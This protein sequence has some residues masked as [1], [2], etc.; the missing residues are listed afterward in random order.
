TRQLLLKP[1]I[2]KAPEH[3]AASAPSTLRLSKGSL[4]TPLILFGY[5][6][7]GS[8][9]E[10]QIYPTEQAT[11]SVPSAQEN[12]SSPS[13]PRGSY[14]GYTTRSPRSSIALTAEP[15]NGRL[16]G[17]SPP[18]A[19]TSASFPA[20]SRDVPSYSFCTIAYKRPR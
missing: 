6:A 17:N 2:T 7:A 4:R 12:P 8:A 19:P 20:T 10:Q 9:T 16:N 11:C 5:R 3:R 1:A 15:L 14:D 13:P 18:R